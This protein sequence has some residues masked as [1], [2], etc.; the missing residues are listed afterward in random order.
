MKTTSKTKPAIPRT[1]RTTEKPLVE[2]EDEIFK[3]W[4]W[5]VI[6]EKDIPHCSLWWRHSDGREQAGQ[7]L[8]PDLSGW[9]RKFEKLRTP[10][11]GYTTYPVLS[12]VY[13]SLWPAEK[14]E[15]IANL[16]IPAMTGGVRGKTPEEA[17]TRLYHAAIEAGC[18]VMV[19]ATP[20]AEKAV[21]RKKSSSKIS[22]VK[23][24]VRKS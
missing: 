14:V 21:S 20:A 15:Y 11:C 7:N 18:T 1:N 5:K 2:I 12:R 23:R 9:F 16:F 19:T 4:G 22:K 24:K 13:D 10:V 8:M 17:M 3:F 6:K